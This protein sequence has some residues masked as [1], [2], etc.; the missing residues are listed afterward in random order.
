M[1]NLTLLS[2]ILS[3]M[4]R[5]QSINKVEEQYKVRDIDEAIRTIRRTTQLP[6]TLKKSTLRVF[7]GV[8]EYPVE[9]D[10]DEIAFFDNDS[11]TWAN[12]PRT[13]Y[14][15]VQEFYEDPNNRNDLAEIFDNGTRYL[16]LRYKGANGSSSS[17]LNSAETLSEWSGA[18]DVGTLAKDSVFF[19][20][21]S[22]SIRVPITL[23][24]S[25]ATI[26]NTV[27]NFSDSN[28]RKRYQFKL[29]YLAALP[30]TISLRLETDSANY[31]ATNITTQ[32]SGAPLKANAWNLIAQDLNTATETG[33]FNS[34]SIA[35]EAV[36]M[37]GAATGIYYIDASYLRTWSL[38]DY[39]YYSKYLVALTGSTTANQEY[40][41]N[42]NEI[43]STDSALIGD[44]EWVDVVQ[45]EAEL[46]TLSDEENE[47]VYRKVETKRNNAWEELYK[48]YPSMRPVITTTRYN[49][50]T[51]YTARYG[52]SETNIQ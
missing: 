6:W 11:K 40:F 50:E 46:S 39:Y 25:T 23:A 28:Y 9:A 1:P 13:R 47:A 29:I 20:E 33:T 21:G 10:H 17:L 2:T 16:G 19:K 37:T 43:Y 42:S 5:K 7:D 41:Y 34:A 4:N 49:Y 31:L 27:T 51:D 52:I 45:Y 26:R 36:V 22:A 3:R 30:T 8:L 32:F 18:G 24:A 35:S 38:L 12:K 48:I 14:T 44:S 15:S